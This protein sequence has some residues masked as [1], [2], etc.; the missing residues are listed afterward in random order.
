MLQHGI[1]RST[2]EDGTFHE[3]LVGQLGKLNKITSQSDVRWSQRLLAEPDHSLP[4]AARPQRG[5]SVR[6]RLRSP[7]DVVSPTELAKIVRV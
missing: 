2:K 6:A 3:G 5:R 7:W 4:E 1:I